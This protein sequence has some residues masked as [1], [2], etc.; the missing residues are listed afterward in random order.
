VELHIFSFDDD[1]PDP[2][3]PTIDPQS[4]DPDVEGEYYLRIGVLG[5]GPTTN[6]FSGPLGI[7][8]CP[9]ENPYL[10]ELTS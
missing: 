4:G 5:V 8:W 3:Q 9:P 2:V 10:V 1:L 7:G 6:D